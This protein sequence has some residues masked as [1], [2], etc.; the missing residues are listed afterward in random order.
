MTHNELCERAARWLQN[1]QKCRL[2]LREVVYYVVEIPDAIGWRWGSS[3]LVEC[4]TSRTDFA[5][6]ARKP[7]RHANAGMGEKR[8]FMT[9]PGLVRPEELPIGWGLLEVHEKA[10]GTNVLPKRVDAHDPRAP[11]G[12][13]AG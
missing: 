11:H 6:D 5:V 8:Y 13:R 10:A 12:E 1:T 2:V 7:F 3:I 4:K 9:E